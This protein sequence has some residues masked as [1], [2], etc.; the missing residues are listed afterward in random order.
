M[1]KAY[2]LGIAM[3]KFH[4]DPKVSIE[5]LGAEAVREAVEEAG[6]NL[7]DIQEIYCGNV[8]NGAGVGQKVM[9]EVG[10]IGMPITN[11]E[12][13]CSSGSNAFREVYFAVALGRIDIGL[14]IGVENLTSVLKRAHNR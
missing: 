9:T 4:R 3:T 12:N 10:F 2:V 13:C 14:A 1:Y 6:I 7:K 8:F 11:I 5:K